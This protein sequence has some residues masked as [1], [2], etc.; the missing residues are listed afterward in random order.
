[1]LSA[2][3]GLD[4]LGQLLIVGDDAAQSVTLQV[5]PHGDLLVRDTTTNSIIPIAGHPDGPGGETNPLDPAAITSQ[6]IRFELGGGADRLDLQLPSGLDVSV[7]DGAG[8]DTTRLIVAASNSPRLIDV[9]S[10]SILLDADGSLISTSGTEWRLQGEVGFGLLDTPREWALEGGGLTITGRLVL[11]DNAFIR[12][13]GAAVDLSS[14]VVTAVNAETALAIDLQGSGDTRLVIGGADDSGGAWLGG[15]GLRSTSSVTFINDPTLIAGDVNVGADRIHIA[16]TLDTAVANGDV[17]LGS[18]TQLTADPAATIAVGQGAIRI[19]GGGGSIELGDAA[20]QSDR[21]GEAITIRG[22]TTVTLGDVAAMS[23]ILTVGVAGDIA[24]DLRQAPDTS[25]FVDRLVGETGGSIELTNPTNQIATILR[26]DVDGNVAVHDAG[27]DLSIEAL[28]A[29]GEDVIVSS[30]GAILVGRI[31]AATADVQLSAASV[32]DA[33]DDTAVDILA[34]R[35]NLSARQG[36]GDSRPLELMSVSELIAESDAGDIRLDQLGDT[37]LELVLVQATEGSVA[38]SSTAALT[39]SRVSAGHPDVSQRHDIRLTALGAATPINIDDATAGS[40]PVIET[41]QGQIILSAGGD[42]T[43]TDRFSGDDGPD[44]KLDPEIVARG[45]HG[46]IDI[47]S[48]SQI[49]LGDDVQL[50]AQQATTR[51]PQPESLADPHDPEPSRDERAVFLR[52]QHVSFGERIEINTGTDQGVARFFAPR[53]SVVLDR[54]DP[55]H[56]KP[57]A[58][59]NPD[60]MPAFFDPFSVDTTIL[61]QALINDATGV[62]TLDIGR[63]GERG[64]T[65]DIDWGAPTDTALGV[66]RFQRLNG[67]SAD[68][69]LFAAVSATGIA[70]DPVV[71]ADSSGLLR[72][73]HFYTEQMILTSRENGRLSA[74][75][76]LEVR[77]S[78]RHHDSIRVEANLV[79]QAPEADKIAVASGII[80]STDD[81]RN[82]DGSIAGTEIGQAA[83]IIPSL[84]IP[85]A[86][87]PVRDVIPE[88][89]TPEF[90]LPEAPDIPLVRNAVATVPMAVVASMGRD[91]F[92]QIRVLSP[93]PF[94]ADLAQPQ[95]LPDDI[96]VGDHLQQLLRSLPDGRYEIEYVLGDGNERTI[97]RVDVRSG[98]ATIPEE[99]LEVQGGLKLEPL[100]WETVPPDPAEPAQAEP[101]EPAERAEPEPAEPEQAEPGEAP[102]AMN[103]PASGPAGETADPGPRREL[104]AGIA[105]SASLSMA[106]RRFRRH[107]SRLSLASRTARRATTQPRAH[108][109]PTSNH[110]KR[111]RFP[112]DTR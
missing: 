74:T 73:E 91:E 99:P 85:I 96:L 86:F 68:D 23:G 79:T 40:A 20:L 71:T 12:G 88:L 13:Q 67:L 75:D 38:I 64:L 58:P 84:T 51:Y 3:A 55:D 9:A 45:P 5:D 63:A 89:E 52:S 46:R 30:A 61:Q 33:A 92:F 78:V 66:T 60:E 39:V 50:H 103:G 72:V 108:D 65:V 112:S 105:L 87:I 90:V 44:W 76:P 109:H 1:M 104:S 36:I 54:S 35:V 21:S 43:I 48:P 22:A 53:P 98:Q 102:N 101:A 29:R 107:P 49:I 42:V 25:L 11:S 93:D 62:L 15:L 10:D 97:L 106:S 32:E 17:N 47:E 82:P 18:V 6:Q 34:A 24:G 59:E 81:S 27:G 14:A 4:A 37:P 16:A 111:S 94:G 2:T 80:S 19:N 100:E 28:G 77:F 110:A 8:D 31:D 69:S 26:F 83:F 56:P 7:I 57:A 41:F 70:A 95:R